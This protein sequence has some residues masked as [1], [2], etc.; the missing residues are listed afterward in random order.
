MFELN[1]YTL[2]KIL[3]K[4]I[5]K[6]TSNIISINLPLIYI[7]STF[8]LYF[9]NFKAKFEYFCK[10]QKDGV[11]IQI[12]NNL[13]SSHPSICTHIWGRTSNLKSQRFFIPKSSQ[14]STFSPFIISWARIRIKI[15]PKPTKHKT[16]L[17]G[18][19]TRRSPNEKVPISCHFPISTSHFVG[20]RWS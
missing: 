19:G 11:K 15:K 8:H 20:K 18:I 1:I 5:R 16:R 12:N 3:N 10:I 17:R 9:P 2:S 6:N 7:S 13:S 14:Y 4:S